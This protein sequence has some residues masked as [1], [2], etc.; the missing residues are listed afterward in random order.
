MIR[1]D[2]INALRHLAPFSEMTESNLQS[3]VRASYLQ[4]FPASTQLIE[5][6]DRADML[7]ILLDGVVELYGSF[8]ERESTLIIMHPVRAFILAAIVQDLPYLMSAR[9]VAPTRILMIPA[10]VAHDL[11]RA[12]SSFNNAMMRALANEFRCVLKGLKSQKLRDGTER[13]A[14]YFLELRHQNND[15]DV[16][17]LPADR[18]AIASYLGMTRENLSRTLQNVRD[19]GVVVRGVEVHFRDVSKLRELAQPSRLIDEM[20]PDVEPER[21]PLRPNRRYE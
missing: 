12:D 9:T 19:H 8:R 10:P 2:D 15:A 3:L 5:E 1:E 17:R 13:I 21:V 20:D 14:A 4:R 7:H 16:V 18:K 11:L 6:G